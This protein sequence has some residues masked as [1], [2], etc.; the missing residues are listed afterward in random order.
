LLHLDDVERDKNI[1]L[2]MQL[3]GEKFFVTFIFSL[4]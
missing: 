1:G 3:E 2:L 4:M